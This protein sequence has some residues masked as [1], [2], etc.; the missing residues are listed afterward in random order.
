M[1]LPAPGTTPRCVRRGSQPTVCGRGSPVDTAHKRHHGARS[2]SPIVPGL[3]RRV[4]P[5]P[6]GALI[7][8]DSGTPPD[9][10]G[11]QRLTRCRQVV[12]FQVFSETGPHR[13]A[14]WCVSPRGGCW[15]WPTGWETGD[16]ETASG[17]DTARRSDP[18]REPARIESSLNAPQSGNEM[19]HA[20]T[21][22]RTAGPEPKFRWRQ[23]TDSMRTPLEDFGES[24][25]G[26]GLA[27]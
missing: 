27:A 13:L 19:G 8:N 17:V 2:E 22:H 1:D 10:F 25:T 15:C 20:P 14:G 3:H 24:P 4:H 26:R 9:N 6:G 7:S 12:D 16:G 11:D 21:T 5:S 18:S 23:R